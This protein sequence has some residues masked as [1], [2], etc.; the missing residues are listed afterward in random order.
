MTAELVG[1]EISWNFGETTATGRLFTRGSA[2]RGREKREKVNSPRLFARRVK[3]SAGGSHWDDGAW[4]AA[5]SASTLSSQREARLWADNCI[6]SLTAREQYAASDVSHN[7]PR[8]YDSVGA[9]PCGNTC[10]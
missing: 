9:A 8:K 7:L 10:N 2:R 6:F 3:V 1:K 4:A 5:A